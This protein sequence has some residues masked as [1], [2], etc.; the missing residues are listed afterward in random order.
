MANLGGALAGGLGGAASGAALG[1]VVPGIGT[2]IGAIAGGALGGLAGLFTGGQGKFKQ[3][4]NK[5]TP[6]QQNILNLLLGVGSDA[7]RDPYASFGPIEQQAREGFHQNTIPTL[8]ERFTS[9]GGHGT[10]ALSSPAFA[11]Q[12]GQAGVGL[13]TQLAALRSQYG[14]DTRNQALQLLQLGLSPQTEMYYRPGSQG[15]GPQLLASGLNM[16]GDYFG[17]KYLGNQLAQ[18][19]EGINLSR[20]QAQQLVNYLQKSRGR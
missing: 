11:S 12:L 9:M 17:Q 16:A 20:S 3:T 2:G 10:A 18:Q 13:E 14:M 1:S 19:P 8:S 4:P 15:A 7:F 5:Y 6:E